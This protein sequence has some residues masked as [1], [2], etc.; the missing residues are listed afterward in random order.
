MSLESSARIARIRRPPRTAVEEATNARSK[1]PVLEFSTPACARTAP[2]G[3]GRRVGPPAA[4]PGGPPGCAPPR[5]SGWRRRP[6]RRGRVTPCRSCHSR[7]RW[8]G[9]RLAVGSSRKTTAGSATRPIATFSRCT[10]PT[11]RSCAGDRRRPAGRPGRAAARPPRR[12]RKPLE[13][14]EQAQVLARAQLAVERRALRHPAGSARRR[15]RRA[16]ARLGRARD[17]HRSV[18]LPA[19]FGP[20]SATRSPAEPRDRGCEGDAPGVA[21]SRA[22]CRDEHA[23]GPVTLPFRRRELP[24]EHRICSRPAPGRLRRDTRCAD[25]TTTIPPSDP[26]SRRIRPGCHGIGSRPCRCSAS[27]VCGSSRTTAAARTGAR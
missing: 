13:L 22:A 12:A 24:F 21:T 17:R 1:A 15:A 14:G 20:S 10:L 6:P 9:S 27:V 3:R 25:D 8:R 7:A 19:P 11:D 16:L 23:G 26:A 5:R 18:V 2:A 4:R